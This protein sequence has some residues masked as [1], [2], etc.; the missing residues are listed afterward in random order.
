MPRSRPRTERREQASRFAVFPNQFTGYALIAPQL[1]IVLVFFI[2]PAAQALAW[3]FTL[4]EP[5]GGGSVFVGL[6]N[7]ERLFTSGEYLRSVR[8]T[9]VFALFTIGLSMGS[10]LILAIF[11]DRIRRGSKLVRSAL[12]WPYAVSAPAVALTFKF[13]FNP[14]IGLLGYLNEISPDLWNPIQNGAHALAM[15]I[16]AFS[17]Q[18]V[19]VDFIFFLAGLQEIPNDKIEAAA[20]DGAGI[21]K[22]LRYVVLPLLTPTFFFLLV[23]NIADSFTHSF[24]IIDVMTQGGPGGAT[25]TMVYRIYADGFIG[26]DLSGSA[27]QSLVLMVLVIGL[28][29]V[30]FRFVERRVHYGGAR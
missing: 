1:L 17:W 20:I 22:R 2:W 8:I 19:A 28:T 13:I 6:A 10:A 7:F 3:S 14:F 4:E 30:Q 12:I 26:L 5:F 15:V 27:A 16:I 11:A 18:N 23:L 9:F 29:L 21:W 24:G 25:K